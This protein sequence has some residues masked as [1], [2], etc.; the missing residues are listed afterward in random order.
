MHLADAGDRF[1]RT[2]LQL[3]RSVYALVSN[4]VDA[5]SEMDPLIGVMESSEMAED[6]VNTH[7][8]VVRLYGRH[9]RRALAQFD[10]Q[11]SR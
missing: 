7:N 11:D 1:W 5:P 6:V 2:D 10:G 4:N 3:G 9:Y 8:A